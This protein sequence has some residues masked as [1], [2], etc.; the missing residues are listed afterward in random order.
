MGTCSGSVDPL[1]TTDTWAIGAAYEPYVGR[2][3][4][5][6]AREL[7]SWLAAPSGLRWLDVGCGT[8]EL[9]RAVVSIA[10]PGK[11]VGVDPSEGF[12]AYARAHTPGVRFEVAD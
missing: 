5:L 11:V 3:S 4:R 2:W 1:S 7:L 8:G 9:S 12:L 10:D 6:V